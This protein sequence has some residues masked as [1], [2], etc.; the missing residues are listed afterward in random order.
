MAVKTRPASEKQIALVDKLAHEIYGERADKYLA[1][2]D[3][4]AILADMEA[5]SLLITGLLAVTKAARGDKARK[6][7]TELPE[8]GYYALNYLDV[9]RFYKVVAGEGKHAGRTFLNRFRSDHQDR[10]FRAEQSAFAAA[11]ADEAAAQEARMRFATE[12]VR[13]Y[14]CGRRLTDAES[15]AR[16]L[17]PDCAKK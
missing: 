11:M 12:Q 10:V 5:T 13:C 14:H 1:D 4:E 15:R 8:P 17:G 2:P 6:A 7:D 16:G 3:V 9:L